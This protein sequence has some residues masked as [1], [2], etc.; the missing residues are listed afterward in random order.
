MHQLKE[1]RMQ[2]RLFRLL[3]V[4]GMFLSMSMSPLFATEL[5]R[6]LSRSAE[7]PSTSS[8]SDALK[9]AVLVG[10]NKY[11]S[12]SGVSTLN[13]AVAD[14]D[15]LKGSL[16]RQGYTVLTLYDG[17]ATANFIKKAIKKITQLAVSDDDKKN[18]TLI[19][20]FSG[21]GFAVDGENY[22]V[23]YDTDRDKVTETGLSLESILTTL[24]DTGIAQKVV[25][26][27]A[28][29]N[30]PGQK[31]ASAAFV[32]QP[33]EGLGIL[34]S[35][36]SGDVSYESPALGGGI[37]SHFLV[38]GLDGGAA[39]T[40][41]VVSL[42]S[43]KRYVERKVP[44]WTIKNLQVVQ[45]PYQA[46]EYTG[47]FQIAM[48]ASQEHSAKPFAVVPAEPLQTPPSNSTTIHVS[49]DNQ[50]QQTD[51]LQVYIDSVDNL[52]TS[53]SEYL[54]RYISATYPNKLELVDKEND[55]SLVIRI[56][57]SNL[58]LLHAGRTYKAEGDL[59][60]TGEHSA[61][62]DNDSNEYISVKGSSFRSENEAV[63]LAASSWVEKIGTST[64]LGTI[65]KHLKN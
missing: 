29:R 27:D 13:Y 59:L 25:F 12:L 44:A 6:G 52:A 57:T 41:G 15:A 11:S 18:A 37:F 64:I 28:C 49:P 63:K 50:S 23:A 60:V 56:S 10:I 3:L 65:K 47:E 21:H 7:E 17:E 19:F 54:S 9:L 48:A 51:R 36:R 62:S 33:A 43:L 38:E 5:E 45:T 58:E 20:S 1:F 34:F 35:T 26:L 8:S 22:L 32:S 46:G 42:H 31:S 24:K 14:V 16:E 53:F 39:N 40:D 4:V 55:A 30:N 2:G 61:E